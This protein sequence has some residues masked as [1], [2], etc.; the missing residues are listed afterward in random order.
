MMG[1]LPEHLLLGDHHVRGDTRKHLEMKQT[2]THT[3]LP[4]ELNASA[5]CLK[6]R[7]QE[8]FPGQIGTN[9]SKPLSVTPVK[10]HAR[11]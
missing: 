1:D 4:R 9:F 11:K 3:P 2:H 10:P 5:E 7:P 8:V 6:I